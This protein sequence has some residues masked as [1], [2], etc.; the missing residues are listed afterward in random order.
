MNLTAQQ[1]A[2]KA[3]IKV[4]TLDAYINRG[5]APAHD[6]KFGN[7]RYWLPETVD[8]WLA[9][10]AGQGARTDRPAQPE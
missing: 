10:R 2:D 1:V 5:Y 7:Q 8:Q 6:G 4:T 9:N 3:G